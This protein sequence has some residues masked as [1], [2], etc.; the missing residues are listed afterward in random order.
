MI[1]HFGEHFELVGIRPLSDA[2]ELA[3]DSLRLFSLDFSDSSGIEMICG[4]CTVELGVLMMVIGA[5]MLVM[6]S[7]QVS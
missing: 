2:F 6:K 3:L 4:N 5:G 7:G 1:E